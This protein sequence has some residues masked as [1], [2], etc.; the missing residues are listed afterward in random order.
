MEAQEVIQENISAKLKNFR[1][2]K[3]LTQKEVA[4]RLGVPS[5]T[6]RSWEYGA[7]ISGEPY[8]GLCHVFEVSLTELL[9]LPSQESQQQQILQEIQQIE[10]M[11]QNLKLKITTL[12]T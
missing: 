11:L 4:H 9:G 12:G 3:G 10:I 2:Q 6:Y 7:A 8:Q 1:L 5:S